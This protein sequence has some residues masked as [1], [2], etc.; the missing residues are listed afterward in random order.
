MYK[1]LQINSVINTG[2]TGRIGEEIGIYVKERGWESYFAYGRHGNESSLITVK[3]GSKPSNY[4]HV[5]MTRLFDKHAMA[6]KSATKLLLDQIKKIKPDIIH[7]HNIHGYYLN[8]PILF[9]FLTKTSTPIIITLHDCWTFTGH[10]SY[11]DVVN[12]N[13]W[14]TECNKCPQTK[15]YPSSWIFD[16]SKEN[17]LM[18]KQ[19]FSNLPNLTLVPVSN[20][21]N[22]FVKK[23]FLNTIPTQVIHNGLDMNKFKPRPFTNLKKNLKLN[24]ENI[25]LGIANI[26]TERK[27]LN[28]FYK[29]SSKLESNY[30]IILVGLNKKQIEDMPKDIIGISR[31]ES[32]EELCE[33]YSMAD[34]FV[35]PTHEDNFPTTNLEALACGTPVITYDTGGSPEAIC[36]DTGI[37]VPKGNME[38]L[39][40]A[41]EDIKSRSKEEIGRKCRAR[42][43]Q[44]FDKNIKY[45][46]YF[47]LYNQLLNEK[48]SHH[49]QK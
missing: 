31:T 5:L 21:L 35:N 13:K 11:F 44:Y 15:I 17:F 18:K 46:Q 30:K 42:A 20:W 45:E 7:I 22:S 40:L 14:Q 47:E 6:S 27:G 39:M 16:R 1:L 12:C 28:D 19:L 4:W 32:I 8:M 48:P 37:V 3:I 25:I 10:C 9:E 34:V 33:Y 49:V 38:E 43:L 23:S 2:S 41:I 26:W 24:G 29:L 36:A